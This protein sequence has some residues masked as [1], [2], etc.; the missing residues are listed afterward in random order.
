[1]PGY[2]RG[3]AARNTPNP[4]RAPLDHRFA[5][6]AQPEA[7]IEEMTHVLTHANATGQK[8]RDHS[9]QGDDHHDFMSDAERDAFWAAWKSRAPG[10]AHELHKL[11]QSLHHRNFDVLQ[12]PFPSTRPTAPSPSSHLPALPPR[13]LD[14]LEL[15]IPAQ[16]PP[17]TITG[18]EAQRI[19]TLIAEH[20]RLAKLLY[21][22]IETLD[23]ERPTF[24]AS[25]E[26]LIEILNP[27]RDLSVQV[28]IQYVELNPELRSTTRSPPE[29]A[30]PPSAT[31]NF[32]LDACSASAPGIPSRADILDIM[33]DPSLA[34]SS[35]PMG[36]HPANSVTHL[37]PT[38]T[39][40]IIEAPNRRFHAF[41][42]RQQVNLP[43]A[44]QKRPFWSF[45]GI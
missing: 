16:Q 13:P 2:I 3:A 40:A 14:A 11:S 37:S 15:H 33:G 6:V 35:K 17:Q 41:C 1:M 29:P 21:E 30:P 10:N 7:S 9:S 44:P 28:V 22:F 36:V 39:L 27:R 25:L 24:V 8:Y 18:A 19:S 31:A 26:E 42:L 12:P 43:Q 38:S 23:D 45:P 20:T 4:A 34:P 32:S 5:Y